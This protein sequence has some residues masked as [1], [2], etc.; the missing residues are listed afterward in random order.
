MLNKWITRSF[1]AALTV[2]TLAAGGSRSHGQALKEDAVAAK[3][4]VMAE[5]GLTAYAIV[6]GAQPIPAEQTAAKELAEY[7]GKVTGAELKIVAES[8]AEPKPAKA[9]YLGWTAFAAGHGIDCAKLGVEESVIKTVGSDLVITGGRPRGTIYGVYDF[10][11]KDLGVY[12]LDRDTE[13]VPRRATL[14]INALD[15]RAKPVFRMRCQGMGIWHWRFDAATGEKN[16]R[17]WRHNRQNFQ[18]WTRADVAYGGYDELAYL[19]DGSTCHNFGWYVPAKKYFAEHPEYY[20]LDKDGKTRVSLNGAHG[21]LCLTHPEVRKIALAKL[22]EAIAADRKEY[23]K[24][25]PASPDQPPPT[26][27]DVSQ[28]DDGVVC[29]CPECR[30]LVAREGSESGPLIDFINKIA[31]GV[32]AKHP[33]VKVQTF[34]YWWSQVPPQTLRP[35]ENVVIRW[36]DWYMPGTPQPNPEPW[37]PLSAPVNAWRVENLR[38]WVAITPGGIN[39]WDYGQ[40]YTWPGFP[41]TCAATLADDL[42]LF[43]DNNATVGLYIE[44]EE[45]MP[46]EYPE[47]DWASSVRASGQ[48]SPLY[49]WLAMQLMI[50]PRQPVE[51]QLATFMDGYYGPAAPAMRSLYDKLVAAQRTLPTRTAA[52]GDVLEIDYVTPAFFAEVDA[53]LQQAEAACAPGSLTLL[54]VQRERLR[55]DSALL[56]NWD[57]LTK[58]L[59][60][61]AAMPFDREAVLARI[62]TRARP[63]MAGLGYPEKFIEGGGI[64][65]KENPLSKYI[66]NWRAGGTSA[67]TSEIKEGK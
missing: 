31:D 37:F 50:D 39:V 42:R 40:P 20:A 17:F 45:S 55:S 7:L 16:V 29:H 8:A 61:G 3:P 47:P 67:K 48:F 35:R 62:E 11:Q 66:A 56:C 32:R 57:K 34:A 12:W 36:C 30:A 54:H 10:L 2:L 43:A 13:V 64:Y 51:P 9:I 63:V 53:L 52:K 14:T 26:I 28:S 25:S 58:K 44:S 19:P 23:P 6:T 46:W 59:A 4:L 24:G 27:Y 5:N 49:N 21:S 38:Q 18:T 60:P 41:F 15:R 65:S 33:E 22:L 1:V